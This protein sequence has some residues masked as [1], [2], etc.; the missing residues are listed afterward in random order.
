M[1]SCHRRTRKIR[2]FIPYS[3]LQCTINRLEYAGIIDIVAEGTGSAI[4]CCSKKMY[5]EGQR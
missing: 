2:V 5:C 4:D 1:T 3:N